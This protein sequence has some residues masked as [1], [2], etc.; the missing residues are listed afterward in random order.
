MDEVAREMTLLSRVNA[1]P[2]NPYSTDVQDDGNYHL[3]LAMGIYHL[4]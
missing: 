4:L 1:D 3:N 2:N